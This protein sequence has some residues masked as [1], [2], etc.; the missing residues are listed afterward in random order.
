LNA[1]SAFDSIRLYKFAPCI[2]YSNGQRKR[3][4]LNGIDGVVKT[5]GS[6][7]NLGQF[8]AIYIPRDLAIDRPY[9]RVHRRVNY[10]PHTC[11]SGTAAG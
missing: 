11:W 4:N 6:E 8:D 1:T 2:S 3:T 10:V 7:F 5:V 9:T